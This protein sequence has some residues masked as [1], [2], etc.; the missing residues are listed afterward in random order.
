MTSKGGILII[1]DPGSG[2]SYEVGQR[3]AETER[4]RLYLCRPEGESSDHLLQIAVE[5]EHNA[6]LDRAS[7]VL[8]RLEEEA[9]KIE[10]EFAKVKTEPNHF[11]NYQ[12][13]FPKVVGSFIPDDQGGRRVNILCFREVED[14]GKVVPLQNLVETDKL[15]ADLRSSAWIMG[16]LLKILI[17]LNDANVVA[18][19]LSLG[20]VLIEPEQHYVIIF[21][22]A[23][24]ELKAGAVG[25]AIT[26]SEIQAAARVVIEVLGGTLEGG[27]PGDGGQEHVQYQKFLFDLAHGSES[28]AALAHMS[29]Y[30][31]VDSLWPR[32]FYPFTTHSR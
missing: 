1:K 27:I 30:K 12:L 5:V 29:F 20:N 24:A 14:V 3:V 25:R 17:F 15:R 7:Y 16:K 32:G 21:S 18:H 31:L 10:E 9:R 4:Y 2:K 19:D 6:A 8:E 13:C 23:D 11:L 28:N 26:R 22:W